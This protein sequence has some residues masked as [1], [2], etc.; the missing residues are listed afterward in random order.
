MRLWNAVLTS[1]II[2]RAIN[3]TEG[4]LTGNAPLE[5]ALNFLSSTL[6][7][8]ICATAPDQDAGNCEE[9]RQALHLLILGSE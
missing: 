3:W 4:A 2:G 9:N 6:F 1:G 7:Q 5:L 8:W